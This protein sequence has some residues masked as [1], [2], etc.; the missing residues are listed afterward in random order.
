MKTKNILENAI[1]E[2][3]DAY[4]GST[5]IFDTPSKEMVGSG[6][7]ALAQGWGFYSSECEDSAI[8]FLNTLPDQKGKKI[9]YK[10]R[11]HNG[12][13]PD[14]VNYV[15][16]LAEMPEDCVRLLQKQIEKS[17]YSGRVSIRGGRVFKNWGGEEEITK[18][19]DIYFAF[20]GDHGFDMKKASQFFLGAG[21]DGF[22]FPYNRCLGYVTF[23]L[24]EVEIVNKKV[25]SDY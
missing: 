9:L 3:I 19:K 15:N 17:R 13:T 4:H 18:T 14:E 24:N 5:N 2:A 25:L 6:L 1:R 22:K 10:V 12:K 8:K 11:L 21:I 7:G 16:W 20:A 23:D